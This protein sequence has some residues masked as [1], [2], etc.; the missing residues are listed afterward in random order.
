MSGKSYPHVQP[1]KKAEQK[2]KDRIT[3]LTKRDRTIM[4]LEWVVNEIK[5]LLR[6]WVG[7]FHYRNCSQTFIRVRNH[8]GQPNSPS[9]Q[10]AQGQI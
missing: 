2:V 6:G 10:E 9:A 4:P 5:A 3:E 8:L 1:S 7:C